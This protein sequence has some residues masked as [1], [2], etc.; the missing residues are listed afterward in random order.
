MQWD[1]YLVPQNVFLVKVNAAFD[2]DGD[3]DDD[4]W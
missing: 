3:D 4:D 1:R 2:T